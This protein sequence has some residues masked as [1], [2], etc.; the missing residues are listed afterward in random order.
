MRSC[1]ERRSVQSGFA[2]AGTAG[3]MYFNRKHATDLNSNCF[4]NILRYSLFYWPLYKRFNN[5]TVAVLQEYCR[6]KAEQ[7]ESFLNRLYSDSQIHCDVDMYESNYAMLT[8]VYTKML[9]VILFTGKLKRR[10]SRSY[11]KEVKIFS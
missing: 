2:V 6:A 4:V 8:H 3:T 5:P 11:L 7:S 10:S 9:Q 1:I